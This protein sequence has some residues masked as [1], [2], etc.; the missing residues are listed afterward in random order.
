MKYYIN[1]LDVKSKRSETICEY[2]EKQSAIYDLAEY[3]LSELSTGAGIYKISKR[4]CR[5]WLEE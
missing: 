3:Q 4:P 2:A 1:R 5:H